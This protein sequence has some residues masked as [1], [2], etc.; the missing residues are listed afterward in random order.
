IDTPHRNFQRIKTALTRIALFSNRTQ[1][2]SSPLWT[3]SRWP[4]SALWVTSLHL[5]GPAV[6]R[7]YTNMC[8]TYGRL[9]KVLAQFRVTVMPLAPDS[10]FRFIL[11]RI[12]TGVD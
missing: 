1:F 10:Y 5:F 6:T 9:Y 8:H 4:R 7:N 11:P 12:S 2:I 3:L